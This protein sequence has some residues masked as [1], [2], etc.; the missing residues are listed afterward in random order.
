MATVVVR[1]ATTVHL[2]QEGGAVGG[3]EREGGAVALTRQTWQHK[4]ARQQ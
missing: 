3:V 2:A 1:E 4:S